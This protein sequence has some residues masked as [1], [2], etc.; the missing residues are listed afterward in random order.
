M[1]LKLLMTIALMIGCALLIG[2]TIRG[3]GIEEGLR[4][5]V[6]LIAW[7]IIIYIIWVRRGS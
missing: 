4:N 1:V 5:L 2:V 7:G 3:V 6:V